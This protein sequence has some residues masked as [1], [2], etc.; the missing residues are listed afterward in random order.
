MAEIFSRLKK[1]VQEFITKID[2]FDHKIIRVPN[3]N[4][5]TNNV[6]KIHE[7]DEFTNTKSEFTLKE[8]IYSIGE[9]F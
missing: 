5:V 1:D 9:Y 7:I 6:I 3:F 2:K 4:F 8:Y